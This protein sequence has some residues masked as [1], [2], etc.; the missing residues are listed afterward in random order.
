[1]SNPVLFLAALILLP[2][3]APRLRAADTA[4]LTPEQILKKVTVPPEFSATV[5]AAP[6]NIAYPVFLSAA[7]DGTLFVACDENGSL[8]RKPDRGRVVM[9][10]DTDGDGVADA[11]TTFAKMDSPRG[12]AWDASTRTLYV[13]H[14][15]NLTA[16]RDA[17]GDGIAESSEDLI[18]GIGFGLDFRGADHTTNG[19]RLGID[20]WIYIAV[21]DYGF[22]KATGKDGRALSLRGG[23]IVRV[24][25][26]GSGMELIV[27]GARNILAVA[28]S[29]TLELF[30]RDNTN[31][32]DDWDDRITFNPLGAQ[33]GYP[34]L[35]RNFAD[36]TIKPLTIF[37]GGSPV[38][39]IF[40]DEPALPKEWAHGFYSVEWGRSQ[41]DLHPLTRDGAGWKAET[42]QFIKMP[43]A[44][45]LE[46]DGAARL[47]AAS[48]DG[49]SYTYAGPNVGYIVR[50]TAK[51]AKPVAVPDFKSLP[52]E[53]LAALVGSDSAVHRF[54]AQRELLVRAPKLA[55]LGALRTIASQAGNL[56]AR[57]AAMFTLKLLQG[58]ASH[59]VLLELSRDADVREYALKALADDPR[60][61]AQVAPAPFVAALRDANPRVRLQ[62]V[63]GLG[64]L[65][66][67]E[68]AASLL[69]MTADADSTVA[70]VAVQAL[71]DLKAVDVSLAALDGSDAAL[72]RGALRVLTGLYEPN[73]VDG[74]LRRLDRARGEL[75]VGIFRTLARLDQQEAPYTDPKMWWGTRPDTSGPI[76]KP[77]RWAESDRIEAALKRALELAQGPEAREFVTTLIRMKVSFPG[78]SE[79][80]MA[81]VG[82]DTAAR[83]DIMSSFISPKTPAPESVL[84]TLKTIA[85]NPLERV[86]LR[87]R[88]LRMLGELVEKDTDAVVEAFAPLA[89]DEKLPEPLAALWEE[90]THDARLARKGPAFATLAR[91]KSPARRAL[92]A[93][94]LVNLVSNPMVRDNRA[95]NT[96]QTAI[97][98][99]WKN[100]EQA[101][102]L[103]QVIARTRANSYV[104][105]VRENLQNPE[106]QVAEAARTTF[107]KLGLAT[108]NAGSGKPIAELPYEEVLA[109]V[110]A[111]PGDPKR[112]QDLF[113]QR[114]C[115]ACH[116]VS[117]KEAPK[118]PMLG[119]IGQRYS[120]AELTES[121]LKPNAKIAQGFESQFFK[122][123]SGEEIEGFV[124]RE[125][126]DSVSVRTLAGVTTEI[127]KGSLDRRE[128]RETSIMPEGLMNAGTADDLA[129]LLAYLESTG[130]K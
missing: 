26:D 66:K 15:P 70:H 117:D 108:A 101:V 44:T 80:M 78:F 88:A 50:L 98:S 19:I 14:P 22:V 118:G 31:D 121:I 105:K 128:R 20:G 123:K 75:R 79:L 107:A 24:R 87:T 96:A 127:E 68:A 63:T 115:F 48:W 84:A 51:D 4:P 76:Y 18:T 45:D 110:A 58:A 99:L 35:F 126:G 122:L 112:G 2:A 67:R 73:V 77:E 33:L 8:D 90:F 42:K 106:P 56:G 7:A 62:A 25:P 17:D 9:C 36:E 69:P 124:V 46:V 59:P 114:A 47:Y 86:E 21:G 28:I 113:L 104:A 111:N 12:V 41:I 85:M 71:R 54:A 94:V 53:C 34:T 116:T 72:Q 61:A 129:A 97:D 95:K 64:R 109:L 83:L 82:D 40:I 52:D 37:G 43:R 93:T 10:R 13:M 23:G 100:P 57:V 32:G 60:V 55:T 92:G 29:P 38:G 11:F 119:G 125:G 91:D 16:Y 30:T 120:R 3:F 130:T 81:K 39:A 6:P 1:M 103:L 102:S 74:L 5:F 89:L 65:E 27:R 49:A